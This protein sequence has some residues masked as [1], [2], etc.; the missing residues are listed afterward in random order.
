MIASTYVERLCHP[1][2]F[3]LRTDFA[4]RYNPTTTEGLRLL[5]GE[6]T[7]VD[8]TFDGRTDQTDEFH[9]TIV[10]GDRS[11]APIGRERYRTRLV[12]LQLRPVVIADRLI[13]PRSARADRP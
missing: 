4:T 6:L 7:F 3:R 13:Q 12:R 2:D 5:S 1:T 8:V 9:F 11:G 10:L